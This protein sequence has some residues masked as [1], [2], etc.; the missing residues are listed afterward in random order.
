MVECCN[1]E[2]PHNNYYSGCPINAS[3]C[4]DK[5]KTPIRKDGLTEQEGRVMDSL[6]EA[7]NTF[8]KIE[9]THP[10]ELSDF[11]DGIHKCQYQLTM[12]VM[13][14]DYPDGYPTYNKQ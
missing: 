9:R 12:R 11:A 4:V 3:N 6:V 2:C 1:I 10:S 7:W 8:A 14:R 5:I 13:R